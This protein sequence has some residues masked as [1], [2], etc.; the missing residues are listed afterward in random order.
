MPVE[1][2]G[3]GPRLSWGVRRGLL[4]C[5]IFP[6]GWRGIRKG[7]VSQAQELGH[8]AERSR[9]PWRGFKEGR[10]TPAPAR[11]QAQPASPAMGDVHGG[12]SQGYSRRCQEGSRHCP[13]TLWS[14]EPGTGPVE[15]QKLPTI[16][17]KEHFFSKHGRSPDLRGPAWVCYNLPHA[18]G[19]LLSGNFLSSIQYFSPVSKV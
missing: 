12:V 19:H 17:K 8:Y 13:R 1:T 15:G 18:M 14:E 4:E 9:E 10:D 11:R 6:E 2:L 3:K 5:V 7:L 16:P